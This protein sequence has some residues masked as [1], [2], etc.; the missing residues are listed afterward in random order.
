M[1]R[2]ISAGFTPR[3]I[4]QPRG[5]DPGPH[6]SGAR[7]RRRARR[8]RLRRRRRL[9]DPDARDRRHHRHSRGRPT[10]GVPPHRRLAP[11]DGSVARHS[12]GRAAAGRDGHLQLRPPTQR[13]E[14]GQ[15]GRRRVVDPR[16]RRTRRLRTRPVLPDPDDRRQRDDPQCI[17]PRAD[18]AARASRPTRTAPAGSDAAPDRSGGDPALVEPGDQL[19]PDRHRATPNSV[20]NNCAAGTGSA[21]SIH[22]PIATRARSSIRTASTSP[23]RRT[24]MSPSAEADRTTASG[25]ASPAPR[26]RS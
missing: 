5:E 10:R 16:D 19:R 26:S 22:R 15:S 23:A 4:A 6:R 13:S 14:A 9:P 12:G 18:G 7:R 3:M 2:L 17:G 25:R 20:A 24:R 11:L 21:C 8:S 1:R